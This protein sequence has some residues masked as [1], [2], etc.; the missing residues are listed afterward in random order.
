[1]I[2]FSKDLV[3]LLFASILHQRVQGRSPFLVFT[4]WLFEF[5]Y[6]LQC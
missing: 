4:F 5:V 3:R 1:M 6:T 2:E